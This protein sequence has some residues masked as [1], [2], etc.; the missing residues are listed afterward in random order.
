[1]AYCCNAIKRNCREKYICP[2]EEIF[3][4]REKILSRIPEHLH[5]FDCQQSFGGVKFNPLSKRQF[6][7]KYKPKVFLDIFRFENGISKLAK[8]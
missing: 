3:L 4:I 8:I 7:V 1:M 6:Y 2:I 5:V